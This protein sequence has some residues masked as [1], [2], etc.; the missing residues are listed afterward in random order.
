M[1]REILLQT[2]LFPCLVQKFGQFR[3]LVVQKQRPADAGGYWHTPPEPGPPWK[4]P[5]S[6]ASQ[7]MPRWLRCV[8]RGASPAQLLQPRVFLAWTTPLLAAPQRAPTLAHS[9]AARV[10]RA[11]RRVPRK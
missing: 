7:A 2:L 1:Q 4:L 11:T 6:A 3:S 9:C 5:T 8:A 10:T